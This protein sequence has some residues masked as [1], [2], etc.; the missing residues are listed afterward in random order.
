MDYSNKKK[1]DKKFSK[2]NIEYM[3][4]LGSSSSIVS[5]IFFI[6][7]YIGVSVIYYQAYLKNNDF[8]PMYAASWPLYLF[9]YGLKSSLTWFSDAFNKIGND[10]MLLSSTTSQLP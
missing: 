7:M 10:T 6:F 3:A 2:K 1:K 4:S 8:G 5:I 9:F